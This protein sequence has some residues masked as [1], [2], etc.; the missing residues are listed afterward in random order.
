MSSHKPGPSFVRACL[1]RVRRAVHVFVMIVALVVTLFGAL[2]VLANALRK[3]LDAW[4]WVWR[5]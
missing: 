5:P 3:L 2:T 1:R 4:R